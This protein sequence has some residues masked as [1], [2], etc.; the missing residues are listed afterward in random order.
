[1]DLG[2]SPLIT[3]VCVAQQSVAVS[4][5]ASM[6]IYITFNELSQHFHLPEKQVAL[7]MGIS[8]TSLKK[9]CRAH[10]LTRWP[11]RKLRS[12]HKTM[13]KSK[14][15][16]S[17]TVLGA[18]AESGSSF[19]KVAEQMGLKEHLKAEEVGAMA[20]KE[21]AETEEAERIAVIEALE[22]EE[23]SPHPLS[24][25][26]DQIHWKSFEV[27]SDPTHQKCKLLEIDRHKSENWP[28]CV[29]GEENA[30]LLIVTDWSTLWTVYKLRRHLLKA[31]G[32][33]E[34][35][36]S[37]DGSQAFLWYT[38]YLAAKQAKT[39]CEQA[40]TRLR[41]VF[42]PHSDSDNDGSASLQ[43]TP[44]QLNTSQH[45]DADH[46]FATTASADLTS[47]A[48]SS[49]GRVLIESSMLKA[50]DGSD[51]GQP[52][53]H[54]CASISNAGGPCQPGSSHSSDG[55]WESHE[56]CLISCS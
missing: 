24:G 21:R 10:G 33:T 6:E 55:D 50:K 23:I 35:Q 34:I 14:Q 54:T 13:E 8:L 19:G 32:G 36:I 30:N 37:E 26:L 3:H 25:P 7:E 12:L 27:V 9:V 18:A 53:P 40:C 44:E 47:L 20:I 11:Y 46:L 38:T 16:T 22:A 51:W 39:V 5:L 15:K 42:P 29:L 43:P 48:E 4:R 17:L 49:P 28:T 41:A 2:S 31:L 52:L 56:W 1:M 45:D